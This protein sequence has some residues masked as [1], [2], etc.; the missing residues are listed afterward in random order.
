MTLQPHSGSSKQYQSVEYK[1]MSEYNC[2]IESCEFTSHS[3]RGI[4]IHRSKVHD[5]PTIKQDEL[6]EEIHRVSK[7]VGGQPT[8]RDMRKYGEYGEVTY[9]NRFGSWTNALEIAGFTENPYSTGED[10]Y[11]WS[12]GNTKFYKT[13]HGRAWR[14]AVFQRDEYTCQDCGD[15]TGGNLNAHHIKRRDEYPELELM[16]WNGVTLCRWC[17][18]ERHKGEDVYEMLKSKAK[19]LSSDSANTDT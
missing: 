1:T 5:E 4:S 11:A 9:H 19:S 14:K 2:P 12:G 6:L 13:K 18:A 16:V 15:D 10:H 7:E 3:Q 17:H 8:F